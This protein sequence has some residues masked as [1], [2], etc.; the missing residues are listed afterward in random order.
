M[1]KLPNNKSQTAKWNDDDESTASKSQFG[2]PIPRKVS[3]T[4]ENPII[5]D[6][7]SEEIE[8]REL[9]LTEMEQVMAEKQTTRGN[10]S[11]LDSYSVENL[12][13]ANEQKSENL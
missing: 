2:L 11:I 3:G 7:S 1:V 9:N 4:E 12:K 5:D 13:I 10:E 8:E 6:V